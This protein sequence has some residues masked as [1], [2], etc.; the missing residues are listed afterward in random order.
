MT[1]CVFAEYYN[2]DNED[3]NRIGS[4]SCRRRN[5]PPPVDV[6]L[7]PGG[8]DARQGRPP[9]TSFATSAWP[10]GSGT[11]PTTN[12]QE[13]YE[14]D[15]DGDFQDRGVVF[16]QVYDARHG[17]ELQTPKIRDTSLFPS[18]T[19][20]CP[21]AYFHRATPHAVSR[22]AQM[23]TSAAGANPVIVRASMDGGAP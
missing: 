11:A 19:T 1:P 8:G 21:N 22:S 4:E 13:T 17:L 5:Q 18:I 20:P 9:T 15:A 2:E 3:P 6:T 23:S 10:S 16:G 14:Q 12:R 7:P